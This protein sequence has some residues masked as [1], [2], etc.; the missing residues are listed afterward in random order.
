MDVRPEDVRALFAEMRAMSDRMDA[1]EA[2]GFVVIVIDMDTPAGKIVHAVG[3][4]AT[5]E[6]ALALAAQLDRDPLT[7]L[8]P[9]DGEP[10]WRHMV[11]PLFPATDRER[12]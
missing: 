1:R 5:P 6:Q 11:V 12:S 4:E 2:S 9:A 8:H 10:G 3:P 7:G